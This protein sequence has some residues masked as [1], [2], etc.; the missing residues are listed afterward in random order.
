MHF[1]EWKRF[2]LKES[3]TKIC[4]NW[5]HGSIGSGKSLVR[6]RRNRH[7]AIASIHDEFLSIG[8]FNDIWITIELSNFTEMDFKIPSVKWWSF[9]SGLY[10]LKLVRQCMSG[11]IP[12]QRQLHEFSLRYHNA[13]CLWFGAQP[14]SEPMLA[15]LHET[16]GNFLQWNTNQNTAVL[17]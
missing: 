14:I 15:S 3:L 2:N 13:L 5:Q 6:H 1:L 16:L 11:R 10:V 9:C 17:K 7:Q 12:L 4:T 8:P